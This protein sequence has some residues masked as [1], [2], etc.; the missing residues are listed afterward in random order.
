MFGRRCDN[1][2]PGYY[3]TALD[4]YT[5][6]AEEAAFGPVSFTQGIMGD[7]IYIFILNLHKIQISRCLG[8][9]R[10][11]NIFVFPKNFLK[12]SNHINLVLI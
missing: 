7:F 11:L 4:H 1:I 10:E 12:F 9:F 6:E 5:Y 2:K 8:V 3:F